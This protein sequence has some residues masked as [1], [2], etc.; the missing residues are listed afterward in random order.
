MQLGNIM[1]WHCHVIIF[2]Q[3]RADDHYFTEDLWICLISVYSSLVI[4]NHVQCWETYVGQQFYKLTLL[5]FAVYIVYT[6]LVEFPRK[7]IYERLKGKIDLVANYGSQEFDI[8]QNVLDLVYS[9]TLSWCG[10]FFTPLLPGI[11]FVKCLIIFFIKKVSLMNNYEPPQKAYNASKANSF[12]MTILLLSFIAT[13]AVI[14]YMIGNIHPS[15]S[16]GP[17]RVYSNENYTVWKALIDEILSWPRGVANFLFFL[18]TPAFFIPA[19]GVL[20]FVIYCYWT[21]GQGYKKMQEMLSDHL[22]MEGRDKHFLL[23]RVDELQKRH[24]QLEIPESLKQSTSI[25]GKLLLSPNQ[26][27]D[28]W[29]GNSW[30][31]SSRMVFSRTFVWYNDSF[32]SVRLA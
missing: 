1:H 17:F 24:K 10:M 5:D 25:K 6:F 28:Q 18:A 12:F 20:C 23:A 32:T 31:V 19:F 26:P 4:L 8:P 21:I 27:I 7:T 30:T 13:S 11:S 2:C 29:P 9:Q 3:P 16:C 14:G 15:K 22:K